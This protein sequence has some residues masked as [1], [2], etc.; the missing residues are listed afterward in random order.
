MNKI[1]IMMPIEPDIYGVCRDAFFNKYYV[2]NIIN[3]I[4]SG[5]FVEN[6]NIDL[7]ISAQKWIAHILQSINDG[8]NKVLEISNCARLTKQYLTTFLLNKN[9]LG[10]DII[11][12]QRSSIQ[13]AD[14]MAMEKG[15]IDL[16]K[17][18][19]H[20]Y[21][22]F[23]KNIEQY[24]A[25]DTGSISLQEMYT[26]VHIAQVIQDTR[27]LFGSIEMQL[28]RRQMLLEGEMYNR[29]AA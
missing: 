2:K 10:D 7:L 1:R 4:D 28:Y 27:D 11:N 26:Y 23:S 14:L 21:D 19:D 13:T 22:I 24:I 8:I 3:S 15:T 9:D 17:E 16:M 18:I 5:E 6:R 29:K 25:I 12:A 20:F